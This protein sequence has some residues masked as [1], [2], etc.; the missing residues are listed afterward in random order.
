MSNFAKAAA[1]GALSSYFLLNSYKANASPSTQQHPHMVEHH[2]SDESLRNHLNAELTPGLNQSPQL[3]HFVAAVTN[4]PH[5][6]KRARGGEDGFLISEKVLATAD[7]VGGWARRGVDPG[8]FAKELLQHF[9]DDFR[10]KRESGAEIDLVD[11]LCAA[12]EKTKAIG[13]ST[14][15]IAMLE[16]AQPM[17]RT[18]NLGD[19]GYLLVRPN[20]AVDAAIG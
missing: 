19:S 18:L 10:A 5:Y 7:G 4:I 1:V 12:V 14:C 16:E 17:L 6:K 13:T 2:T 15:V 20:A 3:N 9:W 8:L 11:M